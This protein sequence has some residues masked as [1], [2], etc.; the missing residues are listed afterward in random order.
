MFYNS[1]LF[2]VFV[3]LVQ[4][5]KSCFGKR[6]NLDA[7]RGVITAPNLKITESGDHKI[8]VRT[9]DGG[10]Y[11][12]QPFPFHVHPGPFVPHLSELI[13]RDHGDSSNSIGNLSVIE[14]G[15]ELLFSVVLRDEFANV[16][17]LLNKRKKNKRNHSSGTN[18]VEP[19]SAQPTNCN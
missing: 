2:I 10:C 11:V 16:T 5:K 14:A 3:L 17:T 19:N 8:R 18:K 15:A 9:L 12:G 1:K 13:V 6:R 7:E 4:V